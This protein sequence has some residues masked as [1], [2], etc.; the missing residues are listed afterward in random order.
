MSTRREAFKQGYVAAFGGESNV[1]PA[2]MKAALDW[3]E[4]RSAGSKTGKRA[5][6]S[7]NFTRADQVRKGDIALKIGG[8]IGSTS[9]EMVLITDDPRMGYVR[10]VDQNG[11]RVL[12]HRLMSENCNGRIRPNDSHKGWYPTA[13][14]IRIPPFDELEQ[15][16]G[17]SGSNRRN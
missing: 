13:W 14:H 8:F 17:P 10:F 12:S 6:K 9:G 3:F 15:M 1:N 7:R 2:Q 16:F 4:L 11:N 5:A